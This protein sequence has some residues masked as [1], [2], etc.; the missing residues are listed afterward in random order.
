LAKLWFCGRD[1][2]GFGKCAAWVGYTFGLDVWL[3]GSFNLMD[4]PI[5]F[6]GAS[7]NFLD[8]LNCL[9]GASFNLMDTLIYFTGVSFNFMDALNCLADAIF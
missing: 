8:A 3:D 2:A 6:T 4:A 1:C 7:F 5:C 9:V